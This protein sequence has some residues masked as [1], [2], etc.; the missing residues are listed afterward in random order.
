[1]I[2]SKN[3]KILP[4]FA[5]IIL[6]A[7]LVP[8]HQANASWCVTVSGCAVDVGKEIL[9]WVGTAIG[10][11][12]QAFDAF[13]RYQT[14]SGVY[15]IIVVNQ[16][17]TIIRNFVN[18][19]FILVLIIM[20][21][22]TIFD[23]QKYTWKNMLAPFL[24]AALLINFSLAIGQYIIT[25]SN[26][27][28]GVFLKEIAGSGSI[29]EKFAQGFSQSGIITATTEGPGG[30]VVSAADAVTSTATTLVFGIV[31]LIIILLVFLSLFIFAIVR[32]L[33]LW[34]LLIISPIA[35]FGYALPN[36]R[37]E[38]WSK[39]WNHFLCWCFF[40][41]YYLFFL[42]FAVIFINNKD[43]IPGVA[44]TASV[45]LG[46]MT[47][48]NI[49]FYGITLVILI[50]GLDMAKKLACASGSG[51]SAAFGKIETGVRKYAPGAAYVRGKYTGAKE[52]LAERGKE[53]EEK[54]IFGFGGAQKERLRAAETK[55]WVA[56]IPG[57][58]RVPGA[59]EA[60]ERAEMVEIEK[61]G[62][63]VR[64][65]LLRLPADQQKAFLEDEKKKKGIAGQAAELE[66]VKQGYSKLEDYQKAATRYG[67]E[68]SAFMRQYLENIKQA[69]LSDLFQ[70]PDQELRIARGQ[71]EG[72]VELANLRREFYKDLAKRNRINDVEVYEEAK[73]LLKPIPAEL[74][75]FMDSIKPEYIFG[76]KDARKTALLSYGTDNDQIRDED[77]TKKL[78]DYMSDKDKKE[79]TSWELRE[80]ALEVVAG[81]NMSTNERRDSFEGKRIISEI[82]K[83]N[84]VIN[85]EADMRTTPGAKSF[86]D[87]E[88]LV[89]RIMEEIGKKS[90]ADLKKMSGDF[91]KDPA[92]QEALQR[93]YTPQEL[94]F[95][96]RGASPEVRRA[97]KG[98]AASEEKVKKPREERAPKTEPPKEAPK[99]QLTPGAR[100]DVEKASTTPEE[101]KEEAE[102]QE[103]L[104]RMR[105][106][107]R[108]QRN[109]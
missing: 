2:K 31:W 78:V 4:I 92:V 11:F 73:G 18:M 65:Q 29:S 79:I 86:I 37:S 36:L 28:A 83:F 67:G 44:G 41:P 77:L 59:R 71:E 47:L 17:W 107:L 87:N 72:T 34:F 95:L 54:G 12:A 64:G 106:E 104:E 33:V 45:A 68:N 43:N 56:G 82:N 81:K 25:V 76:T 96:V 61:D 20:A 84:P 90:M 10:W 26:G 8:Q 100:F 101:G 24:I 57:P 30:I 48:N 85:I 74:R 27:L 14:D 21:F 66:F 75:L 98:M 5:V 6:L 3:K 91:F 80:K 13:I 52:G 63:R 32:L 70:S 99:I 88:E 23:I 19:F 22:G 62:K 9:G 46:T 42:M 51:V 58:G 15:N 40:L 109:Q 102:A 38:M 7:V 94:G 97:F 69:K 16:G 39:W 55:G 1:M 93:K 53:I 50:Y 35:W 89:G 105:E 60:A 108:R 103:S 49:L